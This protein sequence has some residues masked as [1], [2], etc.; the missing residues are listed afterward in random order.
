MDDLRHLQ[1]AFLYDCIAGQADVTPAMTPYLTKGA[2]SPHGRMSIYHHSALGNI[3]HA[4]ALTYPVTKA[5]VGDK[6]FRFAIKYYA[7]DTRPPSPNIDEYGEDFADFLAQFEPAQKLPYLPDVAR[8]EWHYQISALAPRSQVIDSNALSAVAQEKYFSLYLHLPASAQFFSS[9]YPVD[10]IWHWSQDN[11]EQ[12]N[13]EG[14]QEQP[15][16]ILEDE[17]GCNILIIRPFAQVNILR[18]LPEEQIFLRALQRG[19]NLF[20]AYEEATAINEEFDL[21]HYLQRHISSA[22]FSGFTIGA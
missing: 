13:G 17:G 11:N 1:Q 9:P 12:D 7:N 15:P 19:A 2:I 14:E 5:L 21:A 8:L 4:M 6:F 16:L 20:E 10:K 3:E 22:T 18:I